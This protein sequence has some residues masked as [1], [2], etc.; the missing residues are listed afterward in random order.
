MRKNGKL[1]LKIA[2]I[3]IPTFLVGIITFS[4]VISF[5]FGDI[6]RILVDSRIENT[7]QEIEATLQASGGLSEIL[8]ETV[9]N[10][11][12]SLTQNQYQTILEGYVSMNET[13]SGSGIWYEPYKYD[14]NRKFF[15]PY[16]YRD[17]DGF[18]FTQEYEVDDYNYPEQDW[19]KAIVEADGEI[20]WTSPYYDESTGGIFITT[21]RVMKNSANQVIGVVT[22]DLD[23][24]NLGAKVND[25]V[26]GENGKTFLLSQENDYIAISNSDKIMTSIYD[27]EDKILARAGEIIKNSEEADYHDDKFHGYIFDIKGIDGANWKIGTLVLRSDFFAIVTTIT[28]GISLLMLILLIVVFIVISSIVKIVKRILKNT[29]EI[30]EGN[31][32]VEFTSKRSDEFGV[33]A[34]GLNNMI[35]TFRD[36]IKNIV[37]SSSEVEKKSES[38]MQRSIEMKDEAKSQADALGEITITMNEMTLAINEVV[39]SANKLAFIMEETL[40]NGESAKESAEEA[41]E[42]SEKGKEDMNKITAEMKGIRQSVSEMSNS[43]QDAGNSAEEIRNIISFI[44]DVAD[45][46]NLLALN[47]AIEAARAG[48]AGK[49]FS[50]VADEIRKLAEST[51]TSTKQISDLVENVIRVISIAVNDTNKNVQGI[52]NSTNLINDT[53]IMFENIFNAIKNTYEKIQTIIDDVDKINLI[54]QD[55]VSTTQEQS[56][57]AEEILA[58][59]ESVNEMSSGLLLNTDQVVNDAKELNEVANELEKVVLRFKI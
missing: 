23:I 20:A 36:I 1:N 38:T 34:L 12:S 47:A 13:I 58:T 44:Q 15:G 9:E 26:I 30:E 40:K 17:G 50:V 14:E 33:L 2:L 6:I 28:I 55:L 16:V 46:T 49:G 5:T 42:I 18:G 56:A 29:K 25:W 4:Y 54:T 52:N 53:G 10:A 39:E 32:T 31:L 41:V 59:V 45:Q 35:T 7:R 22:V 11:G 48:E 21:G 8:A 51:T 27:D 19:Y 43:V 57:G 37:Y 24:A 3:L